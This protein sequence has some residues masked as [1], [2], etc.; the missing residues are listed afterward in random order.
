MLS[1]KSIME[2]FAVLF[3]FFVIFAFTASAQITINIPKFPKI[4][5][6]TSRSEPS[7]PS[8]DNS[9]TN[10]SSDSA[11][12][13][14]NSN[15]C[16]SPTVRANLEDIEKTR[17]EAEEYRPGLRDYYVST[18]DDR[19]NRYFEAAMMPSKRKEWYAN[20]PIDMQNCFDPAL[21]ALAAAAKKTLPPSAGAMPTHGGLFIGLFSGAVLM[22]GA[23]TYLPALALGPMA[24]HLALW[25]GR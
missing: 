13:N 18:L 19:K 25:A 20:M 3:A 9:S 12:S 11:L 7:Q 21:D 6:N 10:T 24:E 14:S 4:K 1:G 16:T 17:K 23:L 5:K 8:G 2:R 15:A 22:V